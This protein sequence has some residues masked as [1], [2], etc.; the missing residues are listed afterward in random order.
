LDG[1][2]LVTLFWL[3]ITYH[4]PTELPDTTILDWKE[5]VIPC[6]ESLR[7]QSRTPPP[8]APKSSLLA[9]AFSSPP[10]VLESSPLAIPES[11]P[12]ATTNLVLLDMVLPLEF[13]APILTPES[14]PESS[15]SSSL[16]QSSSLSSP[17]S[18]KRFYP[19][20]PQ[21]IFSKLCSFSQEIKTLGFSVTMP[22]VSPEQP[23]SLNPPSNLNNDPSGLRYAP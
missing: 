22:D 20:S 16:V 9:A 7:S 14:T 21:C 5:A 4:Q 13:L 23:R 1:E 17:D 12:P 18:S 10:A 3:G 19:E 11:V 15:P 6:L 8:A 2:T